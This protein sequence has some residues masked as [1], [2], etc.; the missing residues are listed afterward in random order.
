MDLLARLQESGVP[1]VNSP[2]AIEAAVDKYL[3]SAKLQAAGLRTPR[4]VVC[5]TVEAALAS[6][7]ELGGD[8][9]VKPLFGAEGRGIVRINDHALAHRT[10]SLL[11][12]LGAVLYVQRY[13]PHGGYDYRVLLVG[14]RAF[15]MKR[16]N[17]LDWRT[18][19]SRGATAEPLELTPELIDAARTAAAA[20]GAIIAGVD[21]LPDGHGNLYVLE[22]NAVPGWQ[23]IARVT[24][25]DIAR[26]VLDEVVKVAQSGKAQGGRE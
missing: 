19:V 13:I 26:V 25:C 2:K 16:V 18:N 5:Q 24:G 4:T 23:A 17:P 14:D 21:F 1:V 8:V 22:V 3:T 15:G 6:W 20:T 11:V 9:V 10:F 7:E 12:G